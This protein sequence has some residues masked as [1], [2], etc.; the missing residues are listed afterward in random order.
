MVE[1]ARLVSLADECI[2]LRLRA[3][4]P[5]GIL[6]DLVDH[7]SDVFEQQVGVGWW[8]WE[9]AGT[10]LRACLARCGGQKGR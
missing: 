10:G 6:L 3:V 7:R 9:G 8:G 5:P 4:L 2:G 1:G